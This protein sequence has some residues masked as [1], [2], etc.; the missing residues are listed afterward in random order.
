MNTSRLIPGSKTLKILKKFY[1]LQT[2]VPDNFIIMWVVAL[3]AA[4]L[5]NDSKQLPDYAVSSSKRPPSKFW[6]P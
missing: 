2:S 4:F 1:K 3:R 5:W 6:S